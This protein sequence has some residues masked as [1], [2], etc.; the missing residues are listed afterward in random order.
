MYKHLIKI[1]ELKIWV[2]FALMGKSNSLIKI[3]VTLCS[4]KNSNI[5]NYYEVYKNQL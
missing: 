4:V 5:Y 1:R 3:L 2:Y